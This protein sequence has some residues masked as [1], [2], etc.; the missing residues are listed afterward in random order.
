MRVLIHPLRWLI[1]VWLFTSTGI[2]QIALNDSMI[3]FQLPD[4]SGQTVD[5]RD[6]SGDIVLL[7]FF[8]TWCGPC[9]VE[10][11][12]LQDSIWM[13]YK[14]QDLTVVGVDFME[15]V[16]PLKQFIKDL[17][18][19]YP[20][21]RDTAGN[22]FEAYG[23]RGFPSNVLIDRQGKVAYVEEGYNI[24]KLQ[25][26]VDSL[27]NVTD[28]EEFAGERGKKITSFRI[29][30]NYPNPFNAQTTVEFYLSQKAPVTLSIYDI[31]GRRI[32]KE[33]SIKKTGHNRWPVDLKSRSSG[34][35]FYRVSVAE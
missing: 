29:L 4:T 6:L 3:H 20:M 25:D 17:N 7:N 8:A 30:G 2:S 22:V 27:L 28:I 31:T 32:L 26:A 9:Q 23:F 12:Q 33:V 10:A 18:L 13:R 35:Y 1:I 24:L 21:V 16:Q 11:P 14:N 15:H 5:S 34:V 19:T